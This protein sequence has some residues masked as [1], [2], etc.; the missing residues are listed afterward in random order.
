MFQKPFNL[1]YER[2]IFLFFYFLLFSSNIVSQNDIAV[3]AF[4]S[5][6]Y[7]VAVNVS[8]SNPI[9]AM[10]LADSLYTY[11]ANGKQKLK[12]VMLKADILEKQEK[13][14]EAIK[15]AIKAL[16]IAKDE[17]D[18]VF[19]ARIYG[20]L[21][22]QYRTVGFLD[23]GKESIRN[24]V[25][26]SSKISDKDE[27][28]KY[29]AMADQELA[30]YALDEKDF[31]RAIEHIRLAM[32]SYEQE[33]NESFRH[34]LIGNSEEM[35][36]RAYLGL[37]NP[38]RALQHFS[39]ANIDI[40]KAEAGNTLWAALIYQGYSAALL[41]T[42]KL[43]SAK[44]YLN[45]ALSIAENGNHSSLKQ[46]V[47]E[48]TSDYY[49]Q[50]NILDSFSKYDSK[51]NAITKENNAKR[52]A[53]VNDA[54]QS[55][56]EYPN[57]E[58]SKDTLYKILALVIICFIGLVLYF[59][60]KNLFGTTEDAIDDIENKTND[61]NLSTKTENEILD[62]LGE[63]EASNDFLDKNISMSVLI[64]RLHTNTK[65]LRYILKKYKDKDYNNYINELRINYIVEKLNT[66][67]EY[68]NYKISYLADESGFS[69]HSKFSASFRQ[70]VGLSP[71]EYIERIKDEKT[72]SL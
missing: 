17:D 61:L 45:K 13:R 1:C 58:F 27:V 54:Y 38:S 3:K 51:Y 9:K 32:L 59:K 41:K 49:K 18:Y 14:G 68:L 28:T 52:K 70:Q 30:E 62:K 21:S 6:F 47:Y 50:L 56:Q 42:K 20:F 37:N 64:G 48:T 2:G 24:G 31:E 71:S 5:V 11:S 40:N 12:S 36:G 67:P 66:D 53:M 23:K 69:S 65:Y 25:A 72:I 43:D 7:H 26:I 4:D 10:H 33:G 34:F 8:S 16:Q 60:R 55:L 29:K 39:K 46:R 57:S 15:Q 22:T 35:L 63:F 19:Q 44:I